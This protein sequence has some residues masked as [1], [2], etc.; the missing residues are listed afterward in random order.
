MMKKISFDKLLFYL[1]CVCVFL[2]WF[3][4]DAK[5]MGCC[6]GFDFVLGLAI[7]LLVIALFLYSE[8]RTKLLIIITEICAVLLVVVAI[9][10]IGAWQNSFFMASS[11]NFDLAPGLPTYW[12]SLAVFVLLFIA[13]QFQVFSKNNK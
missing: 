1:A 11:W 7:P 3:T 6:W 12:I 10:A 4:W 13:V 8:P 9:I 5:M 2:P